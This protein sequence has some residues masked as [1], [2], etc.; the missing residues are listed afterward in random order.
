[1]NRD[2]PLH[3]STLFLKAFFTML[4]GLAPIWGAMTLAIGAL[5]VFIGML[6]GIGWR[7]GLYFGFVTGTTIGYG[8]IAPTT[9][10][11]RSLAIVIGIIGIINTGLI[12]TVAVTAGNLVAKH[13]GID[14]D[15]RNKLKSQLELSEN[16]PNIS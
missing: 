9:F 5:G 13:A 1:M 10:L 16:P 7:D 3:L 14:R 6:E 11:T 2:H 8:D 15:V 12:V 4:K